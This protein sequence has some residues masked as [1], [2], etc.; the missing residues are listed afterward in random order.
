MFLLN[1]VLPVVRCFSRTISEI[2]S[3]LRFEKF[4]RKVVL[5][6][7]RYNIMPG[8]QVLFE[9]GSTLG[10][11]E[12]GEYVTIYGTLFSQSHGKIIMG[13]YTRL[14]FNSCIRA[15]EKVYIGNYTAIAND[16]VITDNDN[17]PIDPVFRR[18]MKEDTLGGEMRAWHNSAHS[19]IV[20]GENVWVGE[21][22]RIQ[23]GVHIGDNSIIAAGS[24]VTHDIPANCIAAGIPAKVIKYIGDG[25]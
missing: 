14:G 24:I 10:D 17:H 21:K 13:D 9:Y 19:E 12:L 20:I 23:K 1:I 15:V 25:K 16:V 11:I 3:K 2:K 4:K 7:Q 8:A 6:G 18:K 5:K 22:S